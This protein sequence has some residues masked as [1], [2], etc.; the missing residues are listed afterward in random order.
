MIK[1]N[2]KKYN[3]LRNEFAYFTFE[4]YQYN[5]KI[6]SLEVVYHF[7]LSGRFMFHPTLSIPT[8]GLFRQP[9]PKKVLDTLLFNVGMIEL[10][11]Y[12]KATC[13]PKI[14]IKP[15][16]LTKQQISFW[17]K[18]YFNG[19]GE[20]FYTNGIQNSPDNFVEIESVPGES[21]SRF[22]LPSGKQRVI[23]PVGGGKDSAVTLELLRSEFE[24]IPFILNPGKAAYNVTQVAGF[25][26]NQV[27]I[28][29]RTVDPALL[30]LNDKGFL[31]GHTPFSALIGFV[32]VLIAT[33]TGSKFIALSNE[34]SANEPTVE[35]GINHQYTKSYEFE[36]DFREYVSAFMTDDIEYFSFLRPL[37]E[38]GIGRLFSGFP[39]YF[40]PFR[41]CNA[42]SKTGS[43]CG[44]CSKCLFTFIILS[45]FIEP[46]KL[47]QIFGKDLLADEALI[48]VLRQLTGTEPVKPFDCVG[49]TE[50]VVAALYD[51]TNHRNE[52]LPVLLKYFISEIAPV[53]P[54]PAHA[55]T[56]VQ[57]FDNNHFLNERF[58]GILKSAIDA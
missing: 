17:K 19:L 3:L 43:W 32:S 36:K 53:K 51:A 56:V 27:I 34:S 13:S 10:V 38:Y 20:F 46:G 37:N 16:M 47:T 54:P 28:A 29:K 55:G 9:L 30:E 18:L 40:D 11:S 4:N 2:Q 14:I 23:V 49:T 1:R 8:N 44:A 57:S 48:P 5:D 6:D 33:L 21:T 12:W 26:S 52:E 41:S 31:N 25:A 24:T 7:N 50:E 35:P 42:G 22:S 15:F 58:L 39:Q 45:P